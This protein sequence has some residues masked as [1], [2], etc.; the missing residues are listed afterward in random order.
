MSMTGL[1]LAMEW[2]ASIS[3]EYGIAK[4]KA[5]HDKWAVSAG[6]DIGLK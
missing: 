2:V 6:G 4:M 5:V 3:V 1:A